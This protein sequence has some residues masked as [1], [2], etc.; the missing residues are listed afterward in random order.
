VPAEVGIDGDAPGAS[1]KGAGGAVFDANPAPRA[2]FGKVDFF[3]DLLPV[4]GVVAPPAA[5]GAPFQENGGPD[6]WAVMGGEP[7]DIKNGAFCY[8]FVHGQT[9]EFSTGL[10]CCARFGSALARKL[11]SSSGLNC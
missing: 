5:Q 6:A 9:H 1:G 11:K 7:H 3:R 4:F 10:Q 8:L 2:A